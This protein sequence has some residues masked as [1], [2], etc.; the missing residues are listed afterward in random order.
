LVAVRD[1]GFETYMLQDS[2]FLH[3]TLEGGFPVLT[4]AG[5]LALLHGP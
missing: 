2:E 5:Y 3:L 4:F 1:G